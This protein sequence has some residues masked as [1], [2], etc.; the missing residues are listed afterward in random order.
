MKKFIS[1]LLLYFIVAII[2]VKAS[3]ELHLS[4]Q[5]RWEHPR[6]ITINEELVFFLEFNDAYYPSSP[7]LPY[8]QETFFLPSIHYTFTSVE[9]QNIRFDSTDISKY[10][11]PNDL[12]LLG[13]SIELKSGIAQSK[14]RQGVHVSFYPL[15]FNSQN[16]SVHRATSFELVI[17][18]EPRTSTQAILPGTYAEQSVLASGNWFKF[19]VSETGIYRIT[20]NDLVSAGMNPANINP[21][22]LRLYGNG[23]GMLP[24]PNASF[25]HDDLIE[26]AI[27][28]VGE[29]DGVFNQQDYILFYG[30]S[31]HQWKYTPGSA[32]FEHI[33][34]IYDDF[35][36]YFL[37]ADKGFGKRIAE[38]PSTNLPV[39]HIVTT[40]NDYQVYERN[41]TNLMKSGRQWY[42]EVFDAIL[43]RNFPFTFPNRVV[44]SNFNI[45]VSVAARSLQG[46]SFA[47]NINGVVTSSPIA[48]ISNQAYAIYAREGLL[49]RTLQSTQ[50]N[51][52]VRITYNKSAMPSTG[53]LNFIRIHALR[54]LIMAGDQMSFRNLASAGAGKVSEFRISGAGSTHLVWDVTD[55]GNVARQQLQQQGNEMVFRLATDQLREFIVFDP[56]KPKAV[57]FVERV[58]NQNLHGAMVPDMLIVTHPLFLDE[59]NRLAAFH[60]SYSNFDVLVATT[61]QIYNEFSSGKQDVSAIRDFARMLYKRSGDSGKFKYLLL[62]GDASYDYKDRIAN[63]TNFVP[64]WISEQSLD[65][66]FSYVTD[67]YF[68]F[69]DDHEGGDNT[70]ILDIGIGRLPV[71]TVDEAK[72]MVDKSIHYAS[73]TQATM[74][75]WRNYICFVADDEDNNLHISQA[76]TM[77]NQ[78]D[79]MFGAFNLT[80]IYLDAYQQVS[81]PGGERYPEVN[82]DIN[83]RVQQGALIVNYTGHGGTLG[84]AHE[85]VLELADIRSWTN[86]DRMPVFITATCE[87]AYFDDPGHTSA[88]E[89]VILNPNGGGIALF[90]TSRPTYASPNFAIN[91]RLFEYAFLHE[92]NEYLRL[93]D[94]IRLAKQNSGNDSNGRKFLLLGDPALHLAIPTYDVVTTHINGQ[95]ISIPAD[96]LKALSMVTI[97]GVVKNHTGTVLD[98][99]NGTLTP[100][101]FDKVQKITTLGNDGGQ[102]YM[103]YAQQNIIYKGNVSVIN[104]QFEFSFIV[105]KD[106]AYA[107]G[108]GKISY[109]ATDGNRDAHGYDRNLIIGGFNELA[110]ID[111]NGPVIELFINDEKFR[112]G[113]ITDQNPVLLARVSDESGINT[114]GS[115]IGHDIIATLNRQTDKPY[116]LNNFYK[117]DLD[118]YTSGTI[119]YPFFNLPDGRHHLHLKVWD[120]YNNPGEAFTE[121]I[122]A[123]SGVIALQEILNYPNPFRDYT[124]FVVEHNQSG[125]DVEFEISIY[126]LDGRLRKVLRETMKP[127]GFRSEPIRWDGRGDNGNLLE[128]GTYIYRVVVR[129]PLTG[130]T[131]KS[132]KLVIIR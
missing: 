104:G 40:F 6:Q 90:T 111:L 19:S 85:R 28:V 79:T 20:Y 47:F 30:Q 72:A 127:G 12:A 115:G 88:G 55:P 5:L 46:T 124:N 95:D 25:R 110:S 103:F 1:Y 91:K 83:K 7:L 123:S 4:R 62:F 60:T 63:N 100:T 86:Y 126:S 45:Q 29:E 74:A 48:P 52:D 121:F 89:L 65:P 84:W 122:V 97:G 56:S 76:E 24:E 42:G 13:A 119:R 80:K 59:A 58:N 36:Y 33:H 118:T 96:T 78:I 75:D 8:F 92:D 70:N 34:N 130:A 77:A 23:G 116:V 27:V 81:V 69:L 17:K 120:I 98:N 109:Y 61:P 114:T 82:T 73:N 67:D 117:A 101:V 129:N 3:D 51:I 107:Y 49:T 18:Y 87:F 57:K 132:S 131:E 10:I 35:N 16:G 37:T 2:P 43:T 54:R 102:P 14:N 112:F 71:S 26:N 64:V 99:F 94:I 32:S 128:G 22:H 41:T 9:L 106:I 50:E 44:D 11:H 21:Q 125:F 105:P 53:W 15:I 68:G 39:T 113:G 93:G 108:N 38:Q 31:P 66:I